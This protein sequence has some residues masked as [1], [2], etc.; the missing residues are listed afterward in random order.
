MPRYIIKLADKYL[1]W[2]TIVDAPVTNGMSLEEFKEYY[3]SE[4]GVQGLNGLEERLKRVEEKGTSSIYEGSVDEVIS[5]NR[6][7]DNEKKLTKEEI[8]EKY[9]R[10]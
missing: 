1:E 2:S 4:Y 9:C 8:I 7:G 5:G 3:K 6:A 10:S